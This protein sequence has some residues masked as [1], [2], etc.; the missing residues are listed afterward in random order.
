MTKT[1]VKVGVVVFP[2]SNCDRDVHHVLMDTG[3]DP[4]FVWHEDDMPS[5]IGAVI[6]P[7]GF[8]YGDRL[9][10]GAIASHSPIIRHIRQMATDGVPVLGICNGFQI[11]VECGLLP[12]VLLH[13]RTARFVCRWTKI[14]CGGA[15]TPFTHMLS[16]GDTIPVPVANGE[17]R[18]HADPDTI[19][20]MEENGQI[21]FRYAED[22][23]GSIDNIAGVCNPD[24]NVLGMMPH[25]ERAAEYDTNPYDHKPARSIFEGLCDARL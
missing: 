6:L 15:K 12:G 25:P 4:V 10:A 21:V 13:N 23:N 22:V 19:Q 16:D 2:G 9:R 7:G 14:V 8:S 18:Y 17:G 1:N 3:H 20:E 11:L 5:G 24:G